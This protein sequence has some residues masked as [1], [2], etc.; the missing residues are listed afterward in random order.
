MSS[1]VEVE[2]KLVL[3]DE[4]ALE[5]VRRILVAAGAATH[6]PLVQVNHF[7][8]TAGRDLRDREVAL[9]LR[10]A[11]GRH[12]LALKGPARSSAE[13]GMHERPEEELEIDAR[14]AAAIL[15]GELSPLELLAERLGSSALLRQTQEPVGPRRLRH[16]GSFENERARLGPLRL[17]PGGPALVFELDRTRFPGGRI[18]HELEVEIRAA[19]APLVEPLL[20]ELLRAAGVEWRPARSK[21]E[22]FFRILDC[23]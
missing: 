9:R 11:G 6:A 2:F 20:R 3:P 22:R 10:R 12:E 21:A 23:G 15:A 1:G 13:I 18:E 8:D 14:A 17:G 7:F 4:E 5:R 16:L 19:D